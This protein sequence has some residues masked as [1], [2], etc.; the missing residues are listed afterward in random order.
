MTALRTMR[1]KPVSLYV[2]VAV[3]PLAVLLLRRNKIISKSSTVADG[4]I[5]EPGDN[6]GRSGR[7]R[8]CPLLQRGRHAEL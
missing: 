8:T 4:I 6:P 3:L 5:A 1:R 2:H 7:R